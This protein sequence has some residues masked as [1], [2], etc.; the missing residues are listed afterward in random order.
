MLHFL[1]VMGLFLGDGSTGITACYKVDCGFAAS[2]A[3]NTDL[4]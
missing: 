4:T 2:N 1:L 3:A